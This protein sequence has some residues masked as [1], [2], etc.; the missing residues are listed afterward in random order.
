MISL[1][2]N[3]VDTCNLVYKGKVIKD[4]NAQLSSIF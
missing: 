3:E 4:M 2:Y 1:N